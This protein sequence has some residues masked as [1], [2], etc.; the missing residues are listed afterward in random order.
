M[1]EAT[2]ST[3]TITTVFLFTPTARPHKLSFQPEGYWLQ[4]GGIFGQST[5][6]GP[7]FR[8]ISFRKRVAEEAARLARYRPIS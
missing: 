2:A 1:A 3:A 8:L 6:Q 7:R 5:R 4:T